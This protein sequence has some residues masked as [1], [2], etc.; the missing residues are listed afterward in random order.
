MTCSVVIPVRNDAE[1]LRRC[2]RALAAQTRRPDEIVVVDNGSADHLPRVLREYDAVRVVREPVPGVARAAAVG[3]DAAVG[4]VIL[5]CDA[6]SVPPA[7][8]VERHLAALERAMRNTAAPAPGRPGAQG[9]P[10]APRT[11]GVRARPGA[12]GRPGAGAR[13]RTRGRNG[14]RDV[15]AVSG[16]ARFG[17]RWSVAGAAVGLLYITAYRAVAGIALGHPAL[18]GSN[19]AFRRDWWLAVREGIHPAADVH[20]D[21]D[22]SFRI[23]P[24]QRVA[25]DPRNLVTV[26]WRAAVSP[27]RIV[28]QLRMAAET[29][30][31]N[32]AEQRP[33][34][35]LRERIAWA[36]RSHR[37]D[38]QRSRR[39]TPW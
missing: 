9:P 10:G 33:W 5:R 37:T 30:R 17:P 36:L 22:L 18:W 2:L 7:R 13:P 16:I 4:D 19:M 11:P 32:W 34:S 20:D 1:Y 23:T 21:F 24:G 28:R 15:V 27:A 14:G 6:D 26:S 29:V 12:Q 38:G 39:G 3:Y 25:V 31:V 35:R 8:W